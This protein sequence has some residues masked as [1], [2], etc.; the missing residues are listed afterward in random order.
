MA[1]IDDLLHSN[2]YLQQLADAALAKENWLPSVASLSLGLTALSGIAQYI[3]AGV[4]LATVPIQAL[5]NKQLNDRKIR[6]HR[7]Y[8]L[9]SLGSQ[10]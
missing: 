4:G 6:Q 7:F 9:H 2:R 1:E 10:L 8:F 3:A 5:R